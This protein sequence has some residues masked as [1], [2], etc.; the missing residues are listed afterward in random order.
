MEKGIWENPEQEVNPFSNE[1][2]HC[3]D[4]PKTIGGMDEAGRVL[5]PA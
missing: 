2:A 4:E 1:Q 3:D 5:G